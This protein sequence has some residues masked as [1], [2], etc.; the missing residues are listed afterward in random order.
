MMT[1]AE[2]KSALA[3]HSDK[4][5]QIQLPDQS[6]VPA[7]FHIT[8]VAFLKKDFIDCG[9]TIRHEGRCQLQA[10]VADDYDHRVPVSRFLKILEHGAPVLP[11][12]ALPVEV[13]Y[14]HPVISQFPLVEVKVTDETV[15]LVVENRH[16]DCLAKDVC[17]LTPEPSCAPGSGC[18]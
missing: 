12:E 13:E 7:H 17:G 10:W 5:L 2:L 11:T 14:E 8:E 4:I 16:T 1:I 18:C 3:P 9:G 15:T 6:L